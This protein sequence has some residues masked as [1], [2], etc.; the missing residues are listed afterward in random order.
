MFGLSRL[1]LL[2]IGGGLAI[3]ALT[4]WS[5]H[6]RADERAKLEFNGLKQRVTDISEDKET[7]NEIDALPI[8]GVLDALRPWG[9]HGPR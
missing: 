4:A 9:V 2:A 7:D 3:A 6:I 8:D 5:W 1:H